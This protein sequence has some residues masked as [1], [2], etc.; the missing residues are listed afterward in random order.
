M[1]G[2]SRGFPHDERMR[3]Q[4]EFE[5]IKQKGLTVRGRS[6][7]ISMVFAPNPLERRIGF[8]VTKRFGGAVQRNLVRRRLREIY[9][10]NRCRI[11]TGLHMVV[12]PRARASK[13]DYKEMNEEFLTLYRTAVTRLCGNG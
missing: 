13:V 2:G 4:W 9:R 10:L 1:A 3:Y 8:I 6:M 7:T 11:Q 12:I 5:R